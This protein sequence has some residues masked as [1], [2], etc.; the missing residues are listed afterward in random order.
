MST[1]D[2]FR[3]PPVAAPASLARL[4]LLQIDTAVDTD[5]A[6]LLDPSGSG[7]GCSVTRVA[8]VAEARR[9]LALQRYDL[10]VLDPG[11]AGE[12]ASVVLLDTLPAK[13]LTTPVL[14]LC[15]YVPSEAC[16]DRANLLLL[17]QSTAAHTL[18]ATIVALVGG[19]SGAAS[20]ATA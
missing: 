3:F 11:A 8:G 12:A 6:G 4:F 2:T 18:W 10:I 17:K 14:L 20:R 13:N 9:A 7:G 15:D 16:R 5:A 19:S 1:L